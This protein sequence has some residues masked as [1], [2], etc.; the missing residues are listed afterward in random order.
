MPVSFASAAGRS[1]T[2]GLL[3]CTSGLL[4]LLSMQFG[5]VSPLLPQLSE[6]RSH[7]FAAL[8]VGGHPV[9][10]LLGALPMVFVAR[11]FGMH[12]CA[13]VGAVILGAGVTIFAG[14]N[15]LW[16]VLGRFGIGF[17][18]AFCWQAAFA[19]SISATTLPRRGR[20]IGLLWAAIALGGIVGPQLGALAAATTRWVLVVPA[21]LTVV[22]SFFL[23]AVPR[24]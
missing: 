1:E 8:V 20:T 14:L 3:V 10:S 22:V 15:G 11:R 4:L 13:I 17:G 19:W 12:V 7:L 16:L 23:L 6:G 5:T 2:T 9:G 21:A 24:Y 18:G